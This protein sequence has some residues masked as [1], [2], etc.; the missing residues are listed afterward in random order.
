MTQKMIMTMTEIG[1]MPRLPCPKATIQ[2][3]GL[4][5]LTK[6]PPEYSSVSA[7]RTFIIP[8]VATMEF[9]CR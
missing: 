4:S 2:I 6:L 8:R 5:R 9:R 1:T 7:C 3:S